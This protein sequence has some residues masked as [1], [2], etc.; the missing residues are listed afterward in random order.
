M[1]ITAS[2]WSAIVV[3]TDFGVTTDKASGGLNL[4]ARMKKD[5]RR[6]ATSH[7]AVMSIFVL[8]LGTLTLGMINNF[9]F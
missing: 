4:V 9:S 8:F 6:K 7:I 2:F 5:K 1:I 3:E